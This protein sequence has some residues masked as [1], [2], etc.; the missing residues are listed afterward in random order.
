MR[1]MPEPKVTED[2]QVV[3]V[4][5]YITHIHNADNVDDINTLKGISLR[6]VAKKL[7]PSCGFIPVH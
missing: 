4:I 1:D 2:D 5:I 3:Y 6:R 7:I